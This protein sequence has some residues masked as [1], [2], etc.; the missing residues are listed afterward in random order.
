MRTDRGDTLVRYDAGQIPMSTRSGA[1]RTLAPAR[2]GRSRLD[3]ALERGAALPRALEHRFTIGVDGH[4]YS[5]TAARTRV[6]RR[7]PMTVDPPL[8]RRPAT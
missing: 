2:R 8:K 5:F 7:D 4:S 6:E 3:L 1:T